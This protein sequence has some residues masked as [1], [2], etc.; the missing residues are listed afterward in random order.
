MKI[1]VVN[2]PNLGLLGTREPN[3]YGRE[4]LV[5]VMA[6]LREEGVALGAEVDDVQFDGE[7]ELVTA[8]GRARGRYEGVVLN[9]AALTHTSLSLRDAIQASGLPCV[10]VHLSNTHAREPFRHVSLTAPACIGQIM[11]FGPASYSLGLRALVEYLKR[12][13]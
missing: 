13:Q 2:G 9:P 10:E 7:G 6:R 12:K 5:E 4:T 3:L 11:G 1:L 8:V